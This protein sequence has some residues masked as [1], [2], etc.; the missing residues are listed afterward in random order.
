[1]HKISTCISSSS[2]I[3]GGSNLSPYIIISNDQNLAVGKKYLISNLD[4][5]IE[6]KLPS[7]PQEGEV[8]EIVDGAG[9]VDSENSLIVL[10]NNSKLHG[11]DH[12]QLEIT[13]A[14]IALNMIYINRAYGWKAIIF[15]N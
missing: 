2:H 8:I 15:N 5:P 1:M 6:L 12:D 3:V 4:T 10:M 7:D 11:E 14:N 13:T 9:D